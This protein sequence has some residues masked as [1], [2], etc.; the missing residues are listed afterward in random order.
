MALEIPERDIL[1]TI[2]HYLGI[3]GYIFKRNNSGM[4]FGEHKGKSWA[5]KMGEAGWPDLIGM[6]RVGRFV[7]IE[8]KAR[9]G[10]VSEAQKAVLERINK[11]GGLA[12]VARS[13]DDVIEQGL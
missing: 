3:K 1:K 12:F 5:V 9:K 6:N 4:M 2:V 7:G 11:S 10:V 13:L 8:V